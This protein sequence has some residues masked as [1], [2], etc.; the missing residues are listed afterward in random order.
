MTGQAFAEAGLNGFRR[1][2]VV[3]GRLRS[4]APLS[5][6]RPARVEADAAGTGDPAVTNL[7]AGFTQSIP[8]GEVAAAYLITARSQPYMVLRNLGTRTGVSHWGLSPKRTSRNQ[9]VG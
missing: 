7:I 5:A 8:A 6:P 4:R 3:V 9:A 2:A 1:E